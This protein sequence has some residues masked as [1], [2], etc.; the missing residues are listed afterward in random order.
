MSEYDAYNLSVRDSTEFRVEQGG[1][2]GTNGYSIAKVT[3]NMPSTVEYC[4]VYGPFIRYEE[5]I[6]DI[7][8]AIICHGDRLISE[9][10]T[11]LDVV[12][13]GENITTELKLSAPI[14]HSSGDVT[15]MTAYIV[16]ITGDCVI[17]LSGE[18][19]K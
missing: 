8:D 2:S 11:V 1:S 17:T 14:D 5:V 15:V 12:I 6:P 16:T 4:E 18:N 10:T 13:L 3:V 19:P 7:G 9:E